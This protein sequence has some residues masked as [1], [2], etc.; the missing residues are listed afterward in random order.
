MENSIIKIGKLPQEV[1]IEFRKLKNNILQSLNNKSSCKSIMVASSTHG[2]GNSITTIY[3]SRV[4]AEESNSKVLLIDLNFR[5]KSRHY[6]NSKTKGVSEYLLEG[7]PLETTISQT[8]VENLFVLTSGNK[9]CDLAQIIKSK[10]F[11]DLIDELKNKYTY[12]IIDSAPLQ[13]YPESIVLASK[14]DGVLLV[15]Q[16]EEVRKQIVLDTKKKL[17]AVNANILGIVLNRK[18]HYIPKSIYAYL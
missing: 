8:E 9:K 10:G 4:I 2:E 11:S 13:Y 12:I 14:V 16:A 17:S 15:I 1:T 3:L 5:S 7:V 18:K 6:G